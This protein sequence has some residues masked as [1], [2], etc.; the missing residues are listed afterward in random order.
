MY[1]LRKMFIFFYV[2]YSLSYMY[3]FYQLY[4][5]LYLLDYPIIFFHFFNYYVLVCNVIFIN[6]IWW[7]VLLHRTQVLCKNSKCKA[8]SLV[9]FYMIALHFLNTFFYYFCID[10]CLIYSKSFCLFLNTTYLILFLL[11]LLIFDRSLSSAL[12]SIYEIP[13]IPSLCF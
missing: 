13:E 6:N 1:H 12:F 4:S 9:T 2:L 5:P 10:Q 3:F 8:I 7:N 11:D